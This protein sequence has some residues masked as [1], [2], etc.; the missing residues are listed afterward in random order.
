MRAPLIRGLAALAALVLGMLA[1]DGMAGTLD[2]VK[3]RGNLICG[4]SDGRAGFSSVDSQGRWTG[5]DVDSCRAIAAVVL[6]DATKITFVP[7]TVQNRF[8]ALQ[9]GEVDVLARTVTWTL[10]RDTAGGIDVTAVTFYDAQGFL[11]PKSLG[12]K[13]AK[14]LDGATICVLPGST[15]ERAVAAYFKQHGL[16]YK[17]VVIQG[18]KELYTAFFSGRCDV[19]MQSTSGLSSARA[20]FARNPDDFVILPERLGKDPMG[21]AVRHGDNQWKDLVTWVMFALFEAEELGVN[22]KNVDAMLKS[23]DPDVQRL[24]GVVPGVGAGLTLDDRWAYRAIKLVGNYAELFDRN[25][26]AGSPLKL[27]RGQNALWRD[28]GLIFSPSF[29]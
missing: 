20:N 19:Y 22:S 11:V 23:E 15:S 4:V 10:T 16:T 26:G 1:G 12:A 24:L 14:D 21:P 6:G 27:D 9:S 3:A 5:L 2:T 18:Q 7:L 25:M 28:G 29:Q 17:P 8:A 13:T